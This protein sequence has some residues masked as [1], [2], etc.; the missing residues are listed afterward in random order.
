MATLED[1]LPGKVV[2]VHLSYRS[3]AAERGKT[4]PFP[5]YFLKPPT[6]VARSGQ[7]VHRP[8]GCEL[9][10][11]E[12]EVA[13]IIGTRAKRVPVEHAWAHVAWVTAA[14]D[15][16]VYDLRYADSGSNVRSKGA[17]GFTPLGPELLDAARVDPARLHLRTWVNG[18]VVQDAC[19]GEELIFGFDQIVADLSRLM[20][21]EP[22]DVI[23]TG[24]PTGSSVVT[25]GDTVEVEVWVG[26]ADGP[27]D[28]LTT[29]RLVSPI[30]Q[31]PTPLEPIGAMPK[32]DD[33]VRAQAYGAGWTGDRDDGN[34]D[35]LR[36]L[37]DV[38]T[39]T[40]SSQLRKRGLHGCTLDGLHATRPEL[41]MIGFAKTL[42][43]L[44]LREDLFAERGGG[45]N[46]Q[47]RAVDEIAPG[48]VLV[49]GARG[50]SSAGTIG[51]ILALRA[52]LRGATG[53]VTDGAVRDYHAIAAM[54][55][56]VY[57]GGAH[58]AVLGRRHVPWQSDVAVSCGGAL[59]CPGDLIVGDGD[60]VVVVP[61]SIAPEVAR[62]AVEQER[63]E[64]FIFER[65]AAGD[66]VQGLYPLTKKWRPAYEAWSAR[67]EQS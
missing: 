15:F 39:A 66:A 21:L 10:A 52:Q 32:V 31:D 58:P 34:A 48:E 42:E 30:V 64:R 47:K 22:G 27:V 55:L 14:N 49:I 6:S 12:G 9:L 50:Q 1:R 36:L 3:R 25:P 4:P 38:S 65:V 62:D 53:I 41:K 57:T 20:T 59:V 19:L 61:R 5:S 28:G 63:E 67:S 24:T 11:F 7:G 29:G 2:A 8:H 45:Y 43:Y 35:V 51:D 60:G 40:I 33:G 16:G 26:G 44:P 23:L 46:A 18:D 17:D 37:R 54:D 13:L 56:P